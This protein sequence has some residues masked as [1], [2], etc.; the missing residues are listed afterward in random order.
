M[1]KCPF[2]AEEI[3]DEAIICRFCNRSIV[4]QPEQSEPPTQVKI[5]PKSTLAGKLVLAIIGFCLL[6]Y[7]FAQCTGGGGG[8][9]GGNSNDITITYQVTGTGSTVDLTYENASG[10]TEQLEHSLPWTL[11]FKAEPGAFLY[12]S[13]QIN[14]TGTVS[15]NILKNG[16]VIKSAKS[17]GEYVIATCSGSAR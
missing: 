13:A 7:I 16:T 17:S 4:Q 6:A 1:K 5:K 15:C 14:G 12:V 3:Q 10:N 9:G 2:C 8:G 11:V